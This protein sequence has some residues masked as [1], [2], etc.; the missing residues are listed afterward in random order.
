MQCISSNNFCQGKYNS[1]LKLQLRKTLVY[2]KRPL[3]FQL[4]L[5]IKLLS[6]LH[7]LHNDNFFKSSKLKLTKTWNK[8]YILKILNEKIFKM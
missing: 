1:Q 6:C 7:K 5:I 3:I 8:T 4:N 2:C